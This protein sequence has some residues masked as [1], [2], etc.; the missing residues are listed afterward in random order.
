MEIDRDKLIK[1]LE[2]FADTNYAF[3]RELIIYQL[4]FLTYCKTKGVEPAEAEELVNQARNIA[5]P[6]I[7]ELTL[8]D[9][10]S[11]LEKLPQIVDLLASNR[12]EDPTTFLRE[13]KPKG[14]P[15]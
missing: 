3:E 5:S 6:K 8:K 9:H 12:G 7:D 10:R 15:N 13:W 4:A 2:A 1:F 14:P 11:L